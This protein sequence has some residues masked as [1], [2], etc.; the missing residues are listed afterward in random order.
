MRLLKYI[1]VG[2][3]VGYGINYIT[4]KGENG[5]SILDDLTDKAPDWFDHAKRF[6]QETLGNITRG[7]SGHS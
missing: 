7:M 1:I 3:A 6:T 4:K 2:A 5:R